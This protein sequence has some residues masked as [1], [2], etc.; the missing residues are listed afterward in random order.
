MYST[1][2]ITYIHIQWK[3][4]IT[5]IKQLDAGVICRLLSAC[6]YI[7]TGRSLVFKI[8]LTAHAYKVTLH[9]AGIILLNL[10]DIPQL[11]SLNNQGLPDQSQRECRPDLALSFSLSSSLFQSCCQGQV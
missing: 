7:A 11:L 1:T 4:T 10:V 3:Y 5:L 8:G 2:Y 9:L 6:I